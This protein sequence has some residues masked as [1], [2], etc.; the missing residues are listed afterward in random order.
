M[1][2]LLDISRDSIQNTKDKIMCLFSPFLLIRANDV[3]LI[4]L[5]SAFLVKCNLPLTVTRTTVSAVNTECVFTCLPLD[6]TENSH[7]IL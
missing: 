1:E 5:S 2:F 3:L 7:K 4:F 6:P